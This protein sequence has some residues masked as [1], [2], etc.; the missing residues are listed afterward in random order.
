MDKV[1]YR[2]GKGHLSQV[3]Q[4]RIVG[5]WP[6]HDEMLVEDVIEDGDCLQGHKTC[7]GLVVF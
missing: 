1:A 5:V 3:V 2:L 6:V 4:V 7:P